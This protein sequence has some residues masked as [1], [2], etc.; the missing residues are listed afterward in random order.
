MA[1]TAWLHQVRCTEHERESVD[2]LGER[3]GLEY[4]E[5]LRYLVREGAK[6]LGVWPLADPSYQTL[7]D[8]RATY[9]TRDPAHETLVTT[10][11][12]GDDREVGA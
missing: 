7:T 2:T 11:R 3:D 8:A 4:P 9:I 5:A 1:K 6:A 10:F 12:D